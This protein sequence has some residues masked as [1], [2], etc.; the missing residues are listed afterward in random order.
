MK[1]L[2]FVFMALLSFTFHSIGN[3]EDINIAKIK[4]WAENKG[5]EILNIL[6]DKSS[7]EKYLALD[8]ILHEDVDLDYAARFVVGRYWQQMTEE[9]KQTY[10]PL[11]YRYVAALYK[12]FPLDVPEGSITHKVEKII[13][14]NSDFEV[15]CSINFNQQKNSASDKNSQRIGVLFTLTI[16]D[17]KIMVRDLKIAESSL[18]LTYRS[19][20]N[21]MIHQDNDD[22]IEWFL[23]D[24]TAITEDKEHEN[25]QKLMKSN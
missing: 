15:F 20:F 18:L 1:K 19:R 22:E 17:D 3:C 25:E 8:K 7:K 9:Q 14:H 21:K 4:V 12:S 24:L 23:E 6:A 13:P 16:N 2:L 11:F 10:I 5:T